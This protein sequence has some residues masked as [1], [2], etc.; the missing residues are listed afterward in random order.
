MMISFLGRV[1]N[2]VGKGENDFMYS[3]TLYS[4]NT[5]FDASTTDNFENIV[6]K[7][8]I[9]CKKQFLPFPQYFLLNQI[10]VSLFVHI[11][12]ILSFLAVELE[13]PKIGI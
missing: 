4:I 6:G 10:I 3:L 2:I 5:H 13:D 1:E 12:D 9:A 11:F 7:E 8:E